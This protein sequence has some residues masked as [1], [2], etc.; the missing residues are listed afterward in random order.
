DMWKRLLMLS[1]AL[2]GALS[3]YRYYVLGSGP[4]WL[5]GSRSGTGFEPYLFASIGALLF[6]AL[7]AVCFEFGSRWFRRIEETVRRVPAAYASAG[8]TGLI[9]GLL[10][11]VL[12]YPAL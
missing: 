10:V 7:A 9:L 11:S 2:L 12:V 6:V 5:A 1:I 4:A 3:G 8:L